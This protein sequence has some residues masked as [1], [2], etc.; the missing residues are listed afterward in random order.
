MEVI[1]L[2]MTAIWVYGMALFES[3]QLGNKSRVI[4]GEYVHINNIVDACNAHPVL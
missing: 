3:G 1:T 4:N 2:E